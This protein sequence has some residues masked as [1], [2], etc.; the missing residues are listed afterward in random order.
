MI[1]FLLIFHSKVYVEELHFN[2]NV[3]DVQ[4][5]S[6]GLH[7]QSFP[8]LVKNE[9]CTGTVIVCI[10]KNIFM[11]CAL[12][13]SCCFKGQ[14]KWLRFCFINKNDIFY[15]QKTTAMYF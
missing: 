3:H 9:F 13:N 10:D 6:D 5:F 12:A 11:N 15:K 14:K 8:N 2:K 4:Y 1:V 7:F